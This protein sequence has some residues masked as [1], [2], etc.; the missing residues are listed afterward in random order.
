MVVILNFHASLSV[1]GYPLLVP[2]G[3]RYR[4]L[5]NSDSVAYGGQGRIQENQ[6]YPVYDEVEGAER[7]TRI[8]IYLPART[9]LV[10]G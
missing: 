7:V 10:V 3:R 8:R 5:L 4:G 2:P 1:A 9:A 6:E